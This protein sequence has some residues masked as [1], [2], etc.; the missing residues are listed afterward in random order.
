MLSSASNAM[1]TS[2]RSTSSRRAGLT[3]SSCSSVPSCEQ[4]PRPPR[5]ARGASADGRRRAS[6][7]AVDV[8]RTSGAASGAASMRTRSPGLDARRVG[9]ERRR[10]AARRAGQPSPPDRAV[11]GAGSRRNAPGLPDELAVRVDLALRAQVADHVP[12]EPGRVL[13]AG[14]GEARAEREVHRAADLLVEEDVA[15]EAVDLVVQAERDLAEDARAVVHVEQRAQVVLAARGLG[16][17]DAA[18]L[19]A[20]PHVLDLAAV[21]DRREREADLA[22]GLR[23]DRAREHLAVGHVVPPVRGDPR[24]ARRRR[25]RRSV[26]GP[27]IRSSRVVASSSAR[28]VQRL[29]DERQ[30]AAGVVLVDVAGAED[31]PLVLGER[32]AR[33]PARARSSGRACRTSA[34]R[35]PRCAPSGGSRAC[36]AS[37]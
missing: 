33:R 30:C 23:L 4:A 14:L 13:A 37:R 2:A 9:D 35:R 24:R 25:R 1:R 20:Q 18:A 36:A 15:R 29:G 28:A 8:S 6:D 34:S 5:R 11:A 3:Q 10:R 17:D 7:A 32:H 31:E 27:T 21:E 26:S 19:E 16:V 22:L 12:V